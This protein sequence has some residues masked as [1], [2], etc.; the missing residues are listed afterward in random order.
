MEEIWKEYSVLITYYAPNGHYLAVGDSFKFVIG[1]FVHINKGL[2]R[3]ST[4]MTVKSDLKF[5]RKHV[6]SFLHVRMHMGC[7]FLTSLESSNRYLSERTTRVFRREQHAFLSNTMRCF[8][9]L[10]V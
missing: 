3:A 9:W 5:A 4:M 7:Y 1:A 2:L 8:Y 6:E 10:Y